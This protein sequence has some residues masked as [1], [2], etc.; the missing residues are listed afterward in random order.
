MQLAQNFASRIVL[1][2]RKYDHISE[3]LKSLRWLPIAVK[4]L[5]NDSVMVQVAEH[6]TILVK[7]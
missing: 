5:M 6:Q 3:I 7:N 4:L 2:L 1:G